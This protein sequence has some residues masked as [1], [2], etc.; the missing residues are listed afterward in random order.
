MRSA[1]AFLAASLFGLVAACTLN[2]CETGRINKLHS[3]FEASSDLTTVPHPQPEYAS[4]STGIPPVP[5]SPTGAG[6]DGLQ[7][8]ND[9]QARKS[10]GAEK[11]MPMWPR[12]QP[13]DKFI[14]Q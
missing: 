7:P 6:P 9:N 3:R 2:G 13:K 5:G 8:P 11:G 14:R 10:P 1:T 12:M 4:V